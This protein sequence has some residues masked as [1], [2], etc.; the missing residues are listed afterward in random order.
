[1]SMENISEKKRSIQ[2]AIILSG[3]L[4]LIKA[5]VSF[6][7]GSTALLASSLD[8]LMDTGV[9]SVNYL[10]VKKAAQPPD[11]D[12]AYGHEKIESLA[13]Y[14]QGILFILLSVLMF[15][16]SIR[17]IP[18]KTITEHSGIA[19]A[20]ILLSAL[21]N[22]VITLI[23]HRTEK[24]T[25]SLILKAERTHYSIDILSYLVIFISIL[26]VKWTRW[27]GWD[28][29]GGMLLA[30]YVAVL[31]GQ[32]LLNAGN[33]LIDRSLSKP[34]LDDLDNI[35]KNHDPHILDYHEL[36]TRKVGNKS[37]VDFH[38]VLKS[39]QSFKNVHKITESLIE[40]IKTRLKNADVTIHEDPE[41]GP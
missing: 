7:S 17:R 13:S 14:T 26:L 8:S 31:A 34:D 23:L 4:T 30:G 40:K 27:T 33:E 21:I 35:I 15:G 37:F 29:L 1:M 41:Q 6:I 24:K 3:V 38:L 16:E 36:R 10:S 9:S 2:W 12:H 18:K 19:L 20:A 22:S 25:G 5:A 28:I 11:T 32:I 39:N